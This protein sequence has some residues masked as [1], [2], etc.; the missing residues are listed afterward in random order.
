[1]TGTSRPY[2]FSDHVE[3]QILEDL[4][5]VDHGFKVGGSIQT[6]WPVSLVQSAKLE[7]KLPI[8]QV[9]NHTINLSLLDGSEA[10]VAA[11]AV[12]CTKLHS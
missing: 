9:T 10:R 12:I 2:M 4:E 3:A 1:M 5:I 11:D 6:I 8:Q 7:D